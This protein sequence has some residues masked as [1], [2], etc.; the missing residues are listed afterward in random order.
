MG[1]FLVGK[2][3]RYDYLVIASGH[4]F[5]W[6]PLQSILRFSKKNT[7]VLASCFSFDLCDKLWQIFSKKMNPRGEVIFYEDFE[8]TPCPAAAKSV[9]V[10]DSNKTFNNNNNNNNN[11][12]IF[13]QFLVS[14][15]HF[16]DTQHIPNQKE[17]ISLSIESVNDC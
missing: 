5:D 13:I 12:N 15:H 6:Q 17:N 7:A 14:F 4:Q 2:Q 1:S 16:T 3:I 9:R 11:N 10:S 8:P